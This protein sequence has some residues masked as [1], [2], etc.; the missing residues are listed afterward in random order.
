LEEASK[1]VEE[2]L[3]EA[4]KKEVRAQKLHRDIDAMLTKIRGEKENG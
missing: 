1:I 3:V 4:T 2:K